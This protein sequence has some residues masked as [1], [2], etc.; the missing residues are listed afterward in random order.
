MSKTLLIVKPDA[1]TRNLTGFI[2]ERLERA[3]FKVVEMR[4]ITLSTEQAQRFYEVH[5]ERPFYDSLVEYM[6]SGPVV[7]MAL[8]KGNAV[9]DLRVLI[10]ATNPK[11]AEC[12]TIRYEIGRDVQENSVHG[13]DSDENAAGEIA[14]FFRE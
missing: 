10:G 2:I 13:S 4:M 8:E 12:G 3:R 5:K 14:F 11:E 9:S 6:T 7:P 1:T